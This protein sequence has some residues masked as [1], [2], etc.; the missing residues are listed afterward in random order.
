MLSKGRYFMKRS[1]C[2]ISGGCGSGTGKGDKLNLLM[3]AHYANDL[4]FC[5]QLPIGHKKY[6]DKTNNC[7]MRG[8]TLVASRRILPHEELYFAYNV[9]RTC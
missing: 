2:Y 4:E 3:G 9:E 8:S 5:D 6:I 7:E 1:G